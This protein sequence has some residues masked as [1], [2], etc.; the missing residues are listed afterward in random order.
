[1]IADYEV[2]LPRPRTDYDW[3]ATQ[4]YSE[5]RTGIWDLLQAE[6]PQPAASA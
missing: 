1:V 3:R 4:R 6:Q 2:Q 5:L